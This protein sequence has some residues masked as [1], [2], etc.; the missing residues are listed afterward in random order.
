MDVAVKM[1][2]YTFICL[3]MVELRMLATQPKHKKKT[4]T[5]GE[6]ARSLHT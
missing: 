5:N 1:M 2:K 6:E 3:F 4:V